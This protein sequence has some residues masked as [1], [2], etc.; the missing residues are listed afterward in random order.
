MSALQ[1]FWEV[2]EVPRSIRQS[3]EEEAC[4]RMF[5]EHRREA[6]GRYVVR[7]PIKRGA[8]ALL[9]DGLAGAQFAIRALQRSMSLDAELAE[10]YTRF[11]QDYLRLGHM[12][13]VPPA[14]LKSSADK[15]YYIAHHPIWQHGDLAR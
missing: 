5:L 3:P 13:A 6:D 1:R 7:L 2:E 11:M 10:E 15:M 4:E 12:Q 9:E 14:P 8:L